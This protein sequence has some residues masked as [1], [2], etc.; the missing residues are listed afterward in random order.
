MNPDIFS[1]R[2]ICQTLRYRLISEFVININIWPAWYECVRYNTIL[3]RKCLY[4]VPFQFEHT[5]CGQFH[6]NV[7]LV[8]GG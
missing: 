3:L 4:K 2:A 1:D 5:K 6:V 8:V 7:C